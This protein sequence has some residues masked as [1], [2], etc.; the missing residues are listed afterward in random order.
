MLILDPD[1]E[2]FAILTPLLSLEPDGKPL[3]IRMVPALDAFTNQ[4]DEMRAA[5]RKPKE[6]DNE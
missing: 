1:S 5:M 6:H 2:A 3:V 4:S